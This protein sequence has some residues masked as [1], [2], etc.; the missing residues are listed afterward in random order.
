MIFSVIGSGDTTSSAEDDNVSEKY[1]ASGR[2]SLFNGDDDDDDDDDV[3]G[4]DAVAGADAD[5]GGGD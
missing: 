1:V 4:S 3:R 5:G 2:D